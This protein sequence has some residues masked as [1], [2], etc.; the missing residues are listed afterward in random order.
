[1]KMPLV[2][3]TILV[4]EMVPVMEVATEAKEEVMLAAVAELMAVMEVDRIAISWNP[5]LMPNMIALT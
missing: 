4:M 5:V 3:V 1:M 2:G